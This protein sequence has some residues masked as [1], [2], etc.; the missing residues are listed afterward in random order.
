MHNHS[1][2]I[3]HR[4]L[5]VGQSGINV[6]FTNIGNTLRHER[7][8]DEV[9][10]K[11]FNQSVRSWSLKVQR[12]LRSNADRLF[13]HRPMSNVSARFPRL[14][15]SIQAKVRIHQG[16]ATSIGFSIARHGVYLHF[17][18]G[19]GEGGRVGSRWVNKRGWY[20]RTREKSLG[21]AATHRTDVHWFNS[22]IDANID[23]LVEIVS[24]YSSDIAV[25]K[26]SMYIL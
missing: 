6:Q 9:A 2:P 25:N 4:P 16:E 1:S 17:G 8:A 26:T 15:E 11:A 10:L 21:K 18:A 12:Q 3:D 19:R 7:I 22:V 24:T 14:S 13:R 23:E 20:V 5:A